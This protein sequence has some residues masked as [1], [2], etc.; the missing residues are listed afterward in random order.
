MT[1]EEQLPAAQ[2]VGG[3]LN[4]NHAGLD[5]VGELIEVELPVVPAVGATGLRMA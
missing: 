1:V 3:H 2:G 5:R 4:G